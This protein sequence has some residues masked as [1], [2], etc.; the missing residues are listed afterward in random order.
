[1]HDLAHPDYITTLTGGLI[2]RWA[3][4][5]DIPAILACY[6]VAFADHPTGSVNTFA[7]G[8]A[9]GFLTRNHP[10]AGVAD[11]AIICDTDNR[12][13][14]AATI[15]MRTTI[16]YA[17]IPI[18]VGR[19]ELVASHPAVRG[20]GLV[21]HIFAMIHAR[22]AQRGDCLQM[23]AGIPYFYRQ[24]G[25]EYA[26]ASAGS[27]KVP[28]SA[29]PP[30]P[31][32]DSEPIT[33]RRATPSDIPT[34]LALYARDCQRLHDG[35]PFNITANLD[36]TY[37][38]WTMNPHTDAIDPWVPYVIV[39]SNGNSVGYLFT[40]RMRWLNHIG[41]WGIGTNSQFPLHTLF[42]SVARGLIAL[43]DAIPAH[44]SAP[45]RADTLFFCLGGTHPIYPIIETYP[46]TRKAADAWYVRIDDIPQFINHITPALVQR[47]ADSPFAGYV[48]T[49]A[50][51]CYR[52]GFDIQISPG[53]ISAQATAHAQT[54]AV[55]FYPPLVMVQQLLGYRSCQ[56]LQVHY[57]DVRVDATIAP[58]IDVLFPAR[59]TWVVAL[60]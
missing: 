20:R 8:Y 37:L 12:T 24:F 36:A 5:S 34:I 28:F 29:I 54:N 22:S 16:D 27:R 52:F 18:P 53:H 58:L 17:G 13:V 42:A 38:E 1:M 41:I 40:S 48:G 33:L 51:S 2:A 32:S 60:D 21:R 9:Q 35:Q 39:D 4:P 7:I 57:P 31:A 50:V 3:N 14:L 6:G 59:P 26:I 25:Y 47:V 10:A 45:T 55:A 49:I 56:Q 19:P 11:C 43:S 23:I 46:H 44:E 30:L 15:L